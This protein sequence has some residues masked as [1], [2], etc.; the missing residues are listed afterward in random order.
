MDK[1]FVSRR[2]PAPGLAVLDGVAHVSVN[3]HDRPVTRDELLEMG[4]G[5]K[6]LITMLTDRVDRE[7]FAALPDVRMVANYA[8]GY[9][10]IS[11]DDAR[12]AGVVVTNT[13]GV[14][15]AAT[16]DLTMALVLGVMRRMVEGDRLVR[17]GKFEGVSPLYMLGADLGGKVMGIYGMGRIGKAVA[18]RA[19]AFG[20]SVIYHNRREDPEA[21]AELG[22]R[23]VG[24]DELLA[25]SDVVCVTAPLTPETAGRFGMAE[26]RAM[27]DSAYLI[28]SGR[29]PIVK[30]SE[31][32]QALSRGVIA[33]A[34]LD[35]Y[36]EEPK[37]YARLLPL[38]NVVLAPHLGS[39]T[40]EVRERMAVMAAGGVAAFL[41]GRE[42]EHRLT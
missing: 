13:P 5:C 21:R 30:E 23:W 27:K 17:A 34:G 6:A 33:G 26:F 31:L 40:V 42:P 25:A 16:A 14:L 35:V 38:E 3:P 15:T 7:L 10:N 19:L 1:V 8:V 39:A 37:V 20:M 28:N 9:D 24:F 22:A 11:L 18:R 36:E 12:A 41:Q 2:L 4:Q 32:A 29:G